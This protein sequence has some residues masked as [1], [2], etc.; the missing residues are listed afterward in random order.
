MTDGRFLSGSDRLDDI[1]VLLLVFKLVQNYHFSG[2]PI[3]SSYRH[4]SACT[5]MGSFFPLLRRN[6]ADWCFCDT[7]EHICVTVRVLRPDAKK[8]WLTVHSCDALQSQLCHSPRSTIYDMLCDHNCVEVSTVYYFSHFRNETESAVAN[9]D[10]FRIS[11]AA[12]L[13]FQGFA[14]V[15]VQSDGYFFINSNECSR[16]C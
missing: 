1:D 16:R 10:T 15:N 5:P 3:T 2:R 7:T 12:F 11:S 6:C 8:L 14:F 9:T 13:S 4:P